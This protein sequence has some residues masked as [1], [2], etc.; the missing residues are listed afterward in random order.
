VNLEVR[1]LR[2]VT[3]IAAE[4][5]VTRAASRLNLTQSALS[6][7]LAALEERLGTRLFLRVG[8]RMILT[9][10]G[11]ALVASAGPLLEDLQRAEDAV[12]RLGSGRA[13]VLRLATECY[14]CYHWVPP[15]LREFAR[16]W[17]DVELRIVAE[18][19]R[20]PL[21]ALAAGRLDLAVISSPAR[22]RRF[23]TTPL[24]ADELVAVMAPGHPLAARAWLRPADF[25]AEH[26]IL[27][28]SPE[29]STAFQKMLVPAG[30]APRQLSEIQLTEA[31]VEMVKAGLGI[32]ILA[33]WSVGPHLAAGTLRAARLGPRGLLRR[34]TAATLRA[35][36]RREW[37]DAFVRLLAR[38]ARPTAARAAG[39]AS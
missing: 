36:E 27:Y 15:L 2:L 18:A 17:P 30:V 21:E 24:F 25:A 19:T 32:S 37:L 29:E 8:R 14:T 35:A 7:Q 13:G 1:H 11:Q 34:W 38:S 31:I 23:A 5:G 12:T 10:A 20:K 16:T 33:R 28:T 26:L 4:G 6:H 9:L 39:Q 3:A 22:D